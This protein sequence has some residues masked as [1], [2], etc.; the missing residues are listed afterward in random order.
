MDL[1]LT[2]YKVTKNTNEDSFKGEGSS[3]TLTRITKALKELNREA[4]IVEIKLPEKISEETKE[5]LD[6]VT[7]YFAFASVQGKDFVVCIDDISKYNQLGFGNNTEKLFKSNKS[8]FKVVMKCDEDMYMFIYPN[9]LA[10]DIIDRMTAQC[11]KVEVG[12][13]KFDNGRYMSIYPNDD[14]LTTYVMYSKE[15]SKFKTI[16]K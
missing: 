14:W 16:V 15:L 8:V 12:Y 7:T 1:S 5:R 3:V 10:R 13:M 2:F 4:T 9:D 11:I 6:Q